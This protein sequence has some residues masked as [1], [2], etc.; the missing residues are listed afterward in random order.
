M[1]KGMLK[2]GESDIN[3]HKIIEVRATDLDL[4]LIVTPT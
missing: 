1:R 3:F 4:L 2:T